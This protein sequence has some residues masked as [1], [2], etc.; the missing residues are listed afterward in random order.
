MRLLSLIGGAMAYTF[1]KAQGGSIGESLVEDDFIENALEILKKAKERASELV[2]A[3]VRASRYISPHLVDLAERFVI[4]GAPPDP[5]VLNQ[6]A[7]DVLDCADSL[8]GTDGLPMCPTFFEA[9]TAIAFELFRRAHVDVAV[10][11]VGLGGRYDATNVIAP[12][13]GAIT[14]VGLDHQQWLGRTIEA[15]A[16]EKAGIIKPGMDLVIGDLSDEARHVVR[17]VARDQRA[18]MIDAADGSRITR[19]RE[20]ARDV[21]IIETPNDRYG[22]LSLALRGEHQVG[23]ALVAIRLLVVKIPKRRFS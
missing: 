18:Q 5:D 22:P 15:I 9:T 4:G 21:M 6:V 7:R 3:G 10:I 17:D 8:R 14:S 12:V 16:F 1:Q 23:N 11:E 19:D 13:V 20:S 2:A